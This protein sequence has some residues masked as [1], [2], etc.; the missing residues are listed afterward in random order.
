MNVS[1]TKF[2][3]FSN[4]TVSCRDSALNKS[5]IGRTGTTFDDERAHLAA[6]AGASSGHWSVPRESME[7]SHK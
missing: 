4:Y 3:A 6:S 7:T 1:A 2:R 5:G